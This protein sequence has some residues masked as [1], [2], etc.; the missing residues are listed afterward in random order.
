MEWINVKDSHFV[1]IE[2][3]EDGS[4]T[5]IEN[6]NC[7]NK[8]F[9]VAVPTNKGWDINQVYLSEHGLQCYNDDDCGY[10]GWSIEDVTHWMKIKDPYNIETNKN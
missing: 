7:P 3:H 1:D 9:L 8:P 5:W 6:N 2:R 10:Y 4:Y